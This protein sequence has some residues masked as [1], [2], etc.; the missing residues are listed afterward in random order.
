MA[1]VKHKDWFGAVRDCR[2]EIRIPAQM[3]VSLDDYMD[4][5]PFAKKRYKSRSNLVIFLISN[6]LAKEEAKIKFYQSAE[7]K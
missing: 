3:G 4:V 6:F 1:N 7:K 5:I 2:F